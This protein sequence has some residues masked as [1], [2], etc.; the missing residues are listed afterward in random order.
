MRRRAK[1]ALSAR[2]GDYSAAALDPDDA[3]MWAF[4]TYGLANNMWGTWLSAFKC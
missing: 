4:N 2:W 3:T 1:S